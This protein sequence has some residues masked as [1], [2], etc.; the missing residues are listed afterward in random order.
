MTDKPNHLGEYLRA[1][2]A[3]VSPEQAGVP[4]LGGRRVPG[5]R[6]EEVA[7]LAGISADYYLR[8]ERGSDRNPS[9]QV[10][11]SLA[12]V[13]RLD[14]ESTTHLL[15]LVAGRPRPTRRGPRSETVPASMV[16]LLATLPHPAF[17]EGRYF[18]ILAANPLASALSPRLSVGGNQLLDVFLDPAEKALHLDWDGTTECYIASLRRAVGV[19][20]DD[21]RFIELVG[22]LS[23]ASPRFRALWNRHDVRAQR[24]GP[25]RFDH[26]QIGEL[27]L[28]RERLEISGT[29]G[30]HLVLYHAR[31]GSADADKLVLLASS[32]LTPTDPTTGTGSPEMR[33]RLCDR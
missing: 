29:D 28:S 17:V 10:L 12:R 5:L 3:L 33:R 30:P 13:L 4:D 27:R 23:L 22:E 14:D 16:E 20:T 18:D 2:R 26:P 25:I 1:R 31:L 6:R 21:R 7:T 9:A 24:G 8:L 19:E 15:S 11:E 32:T